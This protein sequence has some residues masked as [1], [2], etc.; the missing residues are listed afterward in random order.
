MVL[1]GSGLGD[2]NAHNHNKLPILLG[3]RG[4][5]SIRTGRHIKFKHDVPLNNVFLSMLD[6]AGVPADRFGDSTGRV[7]EL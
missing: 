3:G 2:G 1:Y 5:G 7:K 6:R 4:G